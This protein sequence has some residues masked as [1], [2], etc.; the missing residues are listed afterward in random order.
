METGQPG[1]IHKK[2]LYERLLFPR[3]K[4]PIVSTSSSKAIAF[5]QVWPSGCRFW[6]LL[7]QKKATPQRMALGDAVWHI[8]LCCQEQL[9]HILPDRPVISIQEVHR[10]REP[11]FSPEQCGKLST[12]RLPDIRP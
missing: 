4:R 10:I 1:K 3:P 5:P 7:R 8:C 9:L 12:I 11:A 6:L 2:E